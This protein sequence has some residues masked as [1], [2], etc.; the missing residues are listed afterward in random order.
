VAGNRAGAGPANAAVPTTP[1]S[2]T[3]GRAAAGLGQRPDGW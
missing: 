3:V 2:Q 1:T